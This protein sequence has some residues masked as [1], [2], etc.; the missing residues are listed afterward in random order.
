MTS[1]LATPPLN[2]L[3]NLCSSSLSR[4]LC[5]KNTFVHVQD[6]PVVAR[7]RSR[8]CE[9]RFVSEFEQTKD[10]P[11][12]EGV[13]TIM[14]K[15][16]PSRCTPKEFLDCVHDL[17]FK[18][19][20]GMFHMPRRGNRQNFGYAFLHFWK[21]VDASSFDMKMSGMRIGG[22]KSDKRIVVAHADVQAVTGTKK[23]LKRCRM[24]VQ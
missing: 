23:V 16:I 18:D 21:A 5:V 9:A 12:D 8:S 1:L 17:G 19:K 6:I 7:V 14:V 4:G 13:C 10:C 11:L 22:R 2:E 20:Y 15:N 24:T 3:V